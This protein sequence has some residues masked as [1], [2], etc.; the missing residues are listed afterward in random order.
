M[1]SWKKGF[2]ILVGVAVIL[3]T[4]YSVAQTRV[5]GA[6]P[7]V[8][9]FNILDANRDGK[10]TL[11]EFVADAQRRAEHQFKMIDSTGKGYM[12]PDELCNFMQMM[13]QKRAQPCP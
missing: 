2:L 5:P 12:T 3:G 10:I 11:D 13:R 9:R 1:S 6:A 4:G 8:K 7:C